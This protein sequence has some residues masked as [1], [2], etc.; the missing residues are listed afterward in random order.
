[1]CS[2]RPKSGTDFMILDVQMKQLSWYIKS[3]REGKMFH[4]SND[5]DKCLVNA[6]KDRWL[7][8]SVGQ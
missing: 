7:F 4:I 6:L 8:S 3:F 2:Q 5:V 1:M